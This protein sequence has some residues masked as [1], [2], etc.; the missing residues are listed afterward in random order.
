MVRFLLYNIFMR[1]KKEIF[2]FNWM[3][4]I[5]EAKQLSTGRVCSEIVLLLEL[6]VGTRNNKYNKKTYHASLRLLASKDK[7]N[8]LLNVLSMLTYNKA[9]IEDKCLL[10]YLA[11]KRNF[12]DYKLK[13]IT[14][15]PFEL[16]KEDLEFYDWEN[17]PLLS[18][19]GDSIN[20]KLKK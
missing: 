19:E 3:E 4:L 12:A 17:N 1:V 10:V 13:G 9:S 14:S 20:F 16:V 18:L 6:M 7:P 11:S 5:N 2:R 15:I 8:F